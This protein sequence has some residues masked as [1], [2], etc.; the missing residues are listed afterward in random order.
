[1]NLTL[2]ELQRLSQRLQGRPLSVVDAELRQLH[3]EAQDRIAVKEHVTH[4]DIAASRQR[5]RGVRM[6]AVGE[7]AHDRNEWHPGQ[8]QQPTTEI[9]RLLTQIGVDF[10]GRRLYSERELDDM[11][12][13]AGVT[14]PEHRI[15]VKFE[16]R[17][18][19]LIRPPR[20]KPRHNFISASGE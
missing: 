7:M 6:V 9:E 16:A 8:A 12:Q 20:P 2:R 14:S 19:G 15:A 18:R 13:H 10:S 17:A 4:L 5:P 3:L 11:L 1:M